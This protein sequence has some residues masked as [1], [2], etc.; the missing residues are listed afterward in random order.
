MATLAAVGLLWPAMA[1]YPDLTWNLHVWNR[2][3]QAGRRAPDSDIDAQ[4]RQLVAGLPP[5]VPVGLSVASIADRSSVDQQHLE[6]F[7]RPR[8]CRTRSCSRR[9]PSS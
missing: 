5:A 2:L 6:Q 9:I 4:N 3:R 8:S 7:L 1:A